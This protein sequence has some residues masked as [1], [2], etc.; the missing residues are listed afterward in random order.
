MI[1]KKR[2]KDYTQWYQKRTIIS[3]PCF[4]LYLNRSFSFFLEG[5]K[6]EPKTRPNKSCGKVKKNKS[7]RSHTQTEKTRRKI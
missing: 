7:R 6:K 2:V 4:L 5:K 1:G 3:T